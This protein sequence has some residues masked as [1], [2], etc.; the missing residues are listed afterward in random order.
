MLSAGRILVLILATFSPP[1]GNETFST[2]NDLSTT[3]WSSKKDVS[4]SIHEKD[5]RPRE[6]YS[7]IPLLCTRA[8]PRDSTNRQ[9][10][11]MR[12]VSE[13]PT[14]PRT[15]ESEKDERLSYCVEDKEYQ[16]WSLLRGSLTHFATPRVFDSIK[17]SIVRAT[18]LLNLT[19][20]LRHDSSGAVFSV[21]F[22][23]TAVRKTPLYCLTF[24]ST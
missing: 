14:L 12:C 10:F 18:N 20:P 6:V 11:L 22:L 23:T 2:Q 19:K 15:R 7:P 21:I 3:R 5:C 17:D 16:A 24:L 4:L 13:A 9:Y 1:P 8:S